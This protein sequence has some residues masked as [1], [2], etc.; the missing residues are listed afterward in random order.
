MI[1]EITMKLE[2]HG[3]EVPQALLNMVKELSLC[4]GKRQKGD[5]FFAVVRPE[6]D[7]TFLEIKHGPVTE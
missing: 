7:M 2:I 1:Y 6:P 3:D 5:H 4:I